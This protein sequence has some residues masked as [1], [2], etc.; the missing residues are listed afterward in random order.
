MVSVRRRAAITPIRAAAFVTIAFGI[1]TV[2]GVFIVIDR[3]TQS[4]LTEEDPRWIPRVPGSSNTPV[5]IGQC[6]QYHGGR[7]AGWHQIRCPK[8]IE[9]R[10]GSGGISDH[11]EDLCHLRPTADGPPILECPMNPR[12]R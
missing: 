7:G 12:V 8:I 1:V 10:L 9:D 4:A 2:M 5:E 6:G 11:G 3:G